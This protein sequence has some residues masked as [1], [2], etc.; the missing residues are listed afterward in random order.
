MFGSKNVEDVE[1]LIEL[2]ELIVD[3]LDHG[4][5]ELLLKNVS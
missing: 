3:T 4:S 5:K 2:A 1:E